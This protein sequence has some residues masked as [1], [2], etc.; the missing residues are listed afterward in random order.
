MVGANRSLR[1][2]AAVP[3]TP[4]SR[5]E[6]CHVLAEFSGIDPALANDSSRLRSILRGALIEAGA[7]V[8]GM[9]DKRFEPHGVT[10]LALLSESHASIH[11]YPEL[12]VVFVDVFTCGDSADAGQ[13]V[14]LLRD[15]LAAS[16][17]NVR[18]V[19]RGTGKEIAEPIAPG[20]SHNWH[21]SEAI[22][23][24]RTEFQHP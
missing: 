3:T 20:L 7:T 1:Y 9:I 19:L 22:W 15:E 2:C 14:R 8:C 11:S 18:T 23:D 17:A 13:A 12:G 21:L 16:Q 6:G 10:V 4:G 5:F 24:A